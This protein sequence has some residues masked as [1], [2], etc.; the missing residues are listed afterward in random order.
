MRELKNVIERAVI[1]SQGKVLRLDLSMP[2]LKAE[3]GEEAVE[4]VT[5]GGDFEV[6]IMDMRLPG[7]DGNAAIL[8][9]TPCTRVCASWYTP[10]LP[11]TRC[12]G[13]CGISVCRTPRFS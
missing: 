11:I 12:P 2:E 4:L 8:D 13:H 7:M 5:G 6:C 9:C 10:V 1:L 3:S